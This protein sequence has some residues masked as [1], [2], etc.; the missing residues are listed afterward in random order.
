MRYLAITKVRVMP[1][2]RVKL[3]PE[4]AINAR[5]LVEQQA[6]D[7]FCVVLHPFDFKAGDRF[8]LEGDLP[9]HMAEALEDEPV[10]KKATPKKSGGAEA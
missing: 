7:G 6:K 1:G 8:E 10:A 4:Q 9:K 3:S 2:A 5:H